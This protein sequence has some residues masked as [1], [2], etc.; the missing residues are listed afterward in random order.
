MICLFKLPYSLV[1]LKT[2]KKKAEKYYWLADKLKKSFPSLKQDLK[3]AELP[4]TDKEY[5]GLCLAADIMFFSFITIF[6]LVI[7]GAAA[8]PNFI[9]VSLVVGIFFT[10]FG[11]LQQLYYPKLL[12]IKRIKS[13]EK[14]LLPAL[15]NLYI[16]INSGIPLF[17]S[18]V[19]I[20]KEDYGEISKEF[21][22]AVRNIN[23]GSSQVEALEDL[24]SVNPSLLFRRG[25]WQ[26]INGMKSGSDIGGVLAEILT[27]LSEEQVLQIQRYG[28]QL[29]PLAMFYMLA[30]VIGPS[31]GMTFMIILSSFIGL[32]E[33]GIKVMFWGLYGSVFFFQIMFMGMIKAKRPNLLSD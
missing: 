3:E 16:Q 2:L 26:L 30:V 18:F 14:N 22:R 33:V 1:P 17:D 29:N 24:A 15:Q 20:S 5:L 19:N 25:I 11:L 27:L 12:A 10:L 4:F 13:I 23:A 8:A 7:F 31:L 28:S 9:I 21:G 6:M 32:D